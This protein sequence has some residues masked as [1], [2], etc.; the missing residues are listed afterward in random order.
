ESAPGYL[1]PRPNP[2][3]YTNEVYCKPREGQMTCLLV[4]G[5][6]SI[7]ENIEEAKTCIVSTINP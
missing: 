6:Y 4:P 2:R 7:Y 1:R 3:R 5:G